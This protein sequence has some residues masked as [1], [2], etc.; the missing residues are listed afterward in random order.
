MKPQERL[1]QDKEIL[2]WL[3]DI[4]NEEILTVSKK[5]LVP[6]YDQILLEGFGPYLK[7]HTGKV[8]LD[9][10]SQAWTANIGFANPDI[11]F[12]VGEQLK[13]LTHVRYGFPTIPRIK[14]LHKLASI[15]PGNLK[16]IA[17][18]A[19]GGGAAIEAAFRLAMLN[20]SDAEQFYTYTRGYHGSSL[21]TMTL[22]TRFAGVTRFRPW[23][24]D[25]VSKIP[26]PYCYRCPMQQENEKTCHL[27]C[28]E[29]AKF[30][31]EYGSVDKV[32]GILMEPMQGPG[33]HI[34]A[35]KRYMK[36]LRK[37]TEKNNIYLIFDESQVFTR[38]GHWFSSEYYDNVAPD[39]TCLTKAVGGGLPMGVTI[40]R[41]DLIGFNAA[42]EHSTFG[43]NPLM[44]ASGLVFLNYIEQADLLKNTREQGDYITSQLKKL[45]SKYDMI[46][47][48][49]CPGLFIGVELVKDP[50]T[51]EPGNGLASDLVE[52]ATNQGVIFGHM[53]PISTDTGKLF[54]NVV[55]IKPPLIITREDSDKILEVFESSLEE[56][57]DYM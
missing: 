56:A 3:T 48:I 54:R 24:F 47:D 2:S 23:G 15:A 40:A 43:G 34:P 50:E 18:N 19:M 26:H 4:T 17:V 30:M 45:Q 39:I 16:K 37:W 57:I 36:E 35:P 6:F 32:C 14:F 42:E 12:A 28:L 1:F 13:R 5:T 25:R 21:A 38:I 51:K 9:C 49:R 52:E 44:F 55:K 53:A 27:E 46:G 31:I 33:G 7:D 29:L 20:K 41:D 11:A 8:F 22:S 10:T